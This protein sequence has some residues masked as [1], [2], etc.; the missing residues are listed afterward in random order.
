MS[1]IHLLTSNPQRKNIFVSSKACTLR[2]WHDDL[3]WNTWGSGK[4]VTPIKTQIPYQYLYR[5]VNKERLLINY[6]T[7]EIQWAREAH[8]HSFLHEE[9][10]SF[11]WRERYIVVGFISAIRRRRTKLQFLSMDYTANSGQEV[12]MLMHTAGG[13]EVPLCSWA[14]RFNSWLP[15][16]TSRDLGQRLHFLLLTFPLVQMGTV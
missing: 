10:L 2:K 15:P 3:D 14:T 5:S 12:F 9:K 7:G 1:S 11:P 6:C 13:A 16:E 8:S 4:S